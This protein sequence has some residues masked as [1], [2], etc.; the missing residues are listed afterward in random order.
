M[1]DGGHREDMA[2]SYMAVF[3]IVGNDGMHPFL[4]FKPGNKEHQVYNLW[5]PGGVKA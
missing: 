5:P 3:I 2:G 1:S 4:H